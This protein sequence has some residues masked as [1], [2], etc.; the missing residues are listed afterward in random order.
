MSYFINKDEEISKAAPAG[1]C[2]KKN[3]KQ[4]KKKELYK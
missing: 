4:C 1:S 3:I 2:Y